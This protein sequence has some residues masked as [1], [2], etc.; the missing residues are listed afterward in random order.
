[1][2]T[3]NKKKNILLF[4]FLLIPTMILITGVYFL[5]GY[6]RA[7]EPKETEA[8]TNEQEIH[9]EAPQE[10]DTTQGDDSPSASLNESEGEPIGITE[11]D[12]EQTKELAKGFSKSFYNYNANDIRSYL[13]ASK[14]YMT[15][16]FYE[17]EKENPRRNT[18]SKTITR[19]QDIE[20][21]P[22][23][24]RDS[25]DEIAW[26]ALITGKA[27]SV[28]SVET[29]VESSLWIVFTKVD[30]EWKVKGA[31]FDGW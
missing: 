31:K 13:E 30:S 29:L 7:D 17:F 28:D 20:I 5:T 6:L 15:E 24:G 12:K 14:K 16:E 2:T 9:T 10:E 26:N 27:T 18:L 23:E 4:F 22:V 25:N 3:N 8:E 11:E 21:Y 1:M 19:A